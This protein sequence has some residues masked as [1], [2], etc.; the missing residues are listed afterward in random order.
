MGL[1]HWL[2]GRPDWQVAAGGIAVAIGGFF[3]SSAI[4][5]AV[6]EAFTPRPTVITVTPSPSVSTATH[7]PRGHDSQPPPAARL[8][9][10]RPAVSRRRPPPARLLPAAIA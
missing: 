8:G 4:T 2:A 7:Q 10:R 3:A 6:M 9:A 5:Q 1:R